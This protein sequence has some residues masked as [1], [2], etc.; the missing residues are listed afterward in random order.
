MEVEVEEDGA[1]QVATTPAAF[2]EEPV[3]VTA[4]TLPEQELIAWPMLE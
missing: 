3:W 4:F 1:T 2:W